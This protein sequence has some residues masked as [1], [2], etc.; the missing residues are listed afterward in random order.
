MSYPEQGWITIK[1]DKTK[2]KKPRRPQ[3]RLHQIFSNF[4]S[5]HFSQLLELNISVSG[6]KV[7]PNLLS[8]L[9]TVNLELKIN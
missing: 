7:D 1:T 8:S 6:I 9:L 4:K 2:N 3:K 5:K